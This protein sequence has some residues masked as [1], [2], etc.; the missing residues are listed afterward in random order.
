MNVVDSSR[1]LEYF[2]DGP[3]ASTFAP[4]IKDPAR[5]I[6]PTIS[7]YDDFQ[8][9]LAGKGEDQVLETAAIMY[10]GTVVDLT[11]DIALTA[12]LISHDHRL[13]MADSIILPTSRTYY[14]TL[15]S[16]D[17]DF[18]GLDGVNYFE[19]LADNQI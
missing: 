17:S 9:T 6:V 18:I 12:A 1:W 5:L 11:K 13:P 7:V 4:I 19:R 3:R 16:Q 8:K 2:I 15:W 14:A 10:G